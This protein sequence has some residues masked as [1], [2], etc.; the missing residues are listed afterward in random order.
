[1]SQDGFFTRAKRTVK[2]FVKGAV[3]SLPTSMMVS[4]ASIGIS[5]ALGAWVSP[6]M[7]FLNINTRDAAGI[8]LRFAGATLAGMGINGGLSALQGGGGQQAETASAPQGRGPARHRGGH[9][10][11]MEVTPPF[12]PFNGREQRQIT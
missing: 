4:G 1:M 10:T 2:N 6:E 8:G 7:D 12:T 5:A 9:G 11:A 3:G